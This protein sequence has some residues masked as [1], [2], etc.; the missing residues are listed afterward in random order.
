MVLWQFVIGAPRTDPSGLGGH[1]R[2]QQTV[3]HQWSGRR[4]NIKVAG[5]MHVT[6]RG[7]AGWAGDIYRIDFI[8][9]TAMNRPSIQCNNAALGD[10]CSQGFCYSN[11]PSSISNVGANAYSGTNL[12]SPDF[13]FDCLLNGPEFTIDIIPHNQPQGSVDN[14]ALDSMTLPFIHCIVSLDVTLLD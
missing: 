4:V 9:N 3:Y 11:Y 10:Y 6:S 1:T 2:I 13:Q 12:G 5:V 7:I 8:N 14:T